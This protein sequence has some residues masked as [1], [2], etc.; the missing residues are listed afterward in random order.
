MIPGLLILSS[1]LTDRDETT[2]P[3]CNTKS[4][5]RQLIVKKGNS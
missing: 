5:G 1:S 3:K 4:D 2:P